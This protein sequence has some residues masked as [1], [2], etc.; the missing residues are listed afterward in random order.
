M[1]EDYKYETKIVANRGGHGVNFPRIFLPMRK[2]NYFKYTRRIYR[3]YWNKI[4]G[5][6]K[7]VKPEEFYYSLALSWI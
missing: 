1:R 3:T 6:N 5:E 4:Q 2:R 7:Y